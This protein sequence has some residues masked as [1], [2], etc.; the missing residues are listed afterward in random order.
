MTPAVD[1]SGISNEVAA[2]SATIPGAQLNIV[3]AQFSLWV[4]STDYDGDRPLDWTQTSNEY[5]FGISSYVPVPTNF[6]AAADGAEMVEMNW[7]LADAPEVVLLWSTN[8]PITANHI[9]KGTILAINHAVGNARV[10]YR[11]RPR[12][13]RDGGA[14][15]FGELLPPLRQGRNDLF[16]R[17]R[18]A[19]DEPIRSDAQLRARR[20]RGPVRLHQQPLF[21]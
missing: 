1:G 3:D 7:D 5:T 4:F 10:A 21:L 8:G 2:L 16:R 12:G 20:N 13:V 17:L 19:H 15:Q 18:Y 9:E 6:T 11:G 14:A